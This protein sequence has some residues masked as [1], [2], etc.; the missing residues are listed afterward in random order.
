[1]L[2]TAPAQTTTCDVECR[3][4]AAARAFNANRW[5]FCDPK[6]AIGQ[7]VEYFDRVNFS[8][9]VLRTTR[10]VAPKMQL[11]RYK[12]ILCERPTAT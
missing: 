6:V 12:K 9:C 2:T 3:L 10:H 5:I 4:Q 11:C 1:M 7:K 8:H